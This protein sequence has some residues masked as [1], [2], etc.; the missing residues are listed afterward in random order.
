VIDEP[1]WLA[2]DPERRSLFDVDAPSDLDG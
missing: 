2:F 1:T